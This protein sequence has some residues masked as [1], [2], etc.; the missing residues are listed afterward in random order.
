MKPNT[1][2]EVFCYAV[3]KYSS[4]IAFS[5]WQKTDITY[6]EVGRRVREIQQELVASGLTAG[7]RIAILS[8]NHPNWCISYLAI[9]TAGY[10]AVPIMA[11]LTTENIDNILEHSETKAIIVS[12][13]LYAKVSKRRLAKM[14]VII[15]IKNFKLLRRRV[16]ECGS[17]RTP[18]ADDLA[19]LLYTSGTTSQPK[20]VML[21]HRSIA[22]Q[23]PMLD[24]MFALAESDVLLSVLPLPH[25]YECTIGFLQPF[26]RGAKVV[27][28]DR[29]PTLSVL[30]PALQQIRPTVMYTVPLF[31]EKIYR[32]EVLRRYT[33]NFLMRA[34][35]RMHFVRRIMHRNAGE[36][37]TAFF[38][39][40]LR[41]FGIGGAKLDPT[42]ERFLAES[43]FGYNILYGLTETA[44]LIAGVGRGYRLGS[45]GPAL[46]GIECR[47]ERKNEKTGVGE[48]VVHTPSCMMGYYKNEEATAEVITDDGWF[49]TGDLAKIDSDGWIYIKGRVK[50]MIVGASGENIYPEDIEYVINS[51]LCVVESLVVS[52]AGGKLVARVVFDK[53]A[54]DK[55]FED[56]NPMWSHKEVSREEMMSALKAEIVQSVNSAVSASSRIAEIEV[57]SEPFVRT[58]S[59]KI[60]RYLYT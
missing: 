5:L 36:R 42:V 27:Y 29:T 8:S 15:R 3:E 54:L 58:G 31:I 9:T 53:D 21:S 51:H 37:L 23:L 49:R 40:R 35:Y 47:L 30:M 32:Q 39:G 6:E 38:G 41:F 34:I 26:W 57:E 19:A 22:S 24:A 18:Q 2:Y 48:L 14:N 46:E 45:T 59:N 50:N 10:V 60:K 44:P 43:Q 20:G 52:R 1:L 55:R 28:I 16:A 56:L 17:M 7:D 11:N 25:S 4:R 13:K 33:S 12:D